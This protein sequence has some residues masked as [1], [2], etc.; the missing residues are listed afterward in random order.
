[1]LHNPPTPAELSAL[2]SR[3]RSELE[4]RL[5]S[6]EDCRVESF[7][8]QHPELTS[9]DE[10]AV[11]LILAEYAAREALG[12]PPELGEFLSRFPR[13]HETLRQ[14]FGLRGPGPDSG[15]LYT[16][17]EGRPAEPARP[18][19]RIPLRVGRF[20]ILGRL[21][22]GG[23]GV[24]Y[25]AR[26]PRL[27]RLVA[28]KLIGDGLLSDDAIPRFHIEARALARLQHPNIVA[29]HEIGTDAGRLYFVLDYL[30]GG[31][32]NTARQRFRE[33]RT[34]ARL[35]RK[36]ALGVQAAH[37]AG[38]IH[39]D[40]KPGNVLLDERDEPRVSDF[41]LAKLL[42]ADL[43][44][45]RTNFMM[46]T[47][48]YMA[49]EQTE[50]RAEFR[51]DVWSLGVILYELISGLRPFA[52]LDNK[53]LLYQIL[54]EDPPPLGKLR[55]GV[56]HGLEAI[57]GKCL[58]RNPSDRYPSAA[59]LAEDLARWLRGENTDAQ[60]PGLGERLVSAVRRHSAVAAIGLGVLAL[61]LL[62]PLGPTLTPGPRAAAA[63]AVPK[64]LADEGGLKVPP[65]WRL[66]GGEVVTVKG[67]VRVVNAG[68]GLLELLDHSPWPRYAVTAEVQDDS[69]NSTLVGLFV[70]YNRHETA[71]SPEH[72]YVQH[73]FSESINGHNARGRPMALV[74]FEQAGYLDARPG[75]EPGLGVQVP[76][77][78]R[79]VPAAR[80]AWRKLRV[81]VTPELIRAL[82][83]D[84]PLDRPLIKAKMREDVKR[85]PQGPGVEPAA[86]PASLPEYRPP[87]GLGI[88]CKSGAILVKRVEIAPLAEEP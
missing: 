79:N 86:R 3:L 38:V 14:R 52:A 75:L 66:D 12:R 65:R 44:L 43:N 6:G 35:V 80:G 13:W 82:L 41:G 23:M 81:E 26:D 27:D 34:A 61:L 42:D 58:Q 32:L 62:G 9:S 25:K 15:S 1:M 51:S 20:E 40:L 8:D 16:V 74:L 4:R 67:G 77:A 46:G 69:P 29:V 45:T 55:P 76:V 63:P 39:R 31:S 85:G 54:H 78:D 83:D 73:V 2:A 50:G 17:P 57:V 30:A 48:A 5:A 60:P 49:P 88:V 24:V 33:P 59:V 47:P 87:G 7:L 37:D 72:W 10:A 18:D 71:V 56:P 28:V 19:A 53:Q 22:K 21:G 68:T 84:R 64:L 70:E 11:G 36:L